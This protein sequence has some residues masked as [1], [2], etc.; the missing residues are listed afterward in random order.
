[1]SLKI[2]FWFWLCCTLFAAGQSIAMGLLTKQNQNCNSVT[3][4]RQMGATIW[5]VKRLYLVISV[6]LYFR[7]CIILFVYMGH[8]LE[9]VD[10]YWTGCMPLLCNKIR[11]MVSKKNRN[12]KFFWGFKNDNILSSKSYTVTKSEISPQRKL[13]S[14][15]NLKL[16]LIRH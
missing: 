5:K 1:M 4:C 9:E 7:M 3:P 13:G 14:L 12:F 16:K 6:F 10:A 11:Q 2:V 15:R 8:R